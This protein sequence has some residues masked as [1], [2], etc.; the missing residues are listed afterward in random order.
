MQLN[1]NRWY[2]I[3]IILPHSRGRGQGA[4]WLRVLI[5]PAI[6]LRLWALEPA[7]RGIENALEYTLSGE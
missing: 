7:V 2:V 6:L 1:T 5:H 3:H 4:H